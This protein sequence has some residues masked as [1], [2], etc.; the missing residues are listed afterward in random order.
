MAPAHWR[1]AVA[2]A[3]RLTQPAPQVVR[4]PIARPGLHHGTAA[5]LPGGASPAV[6]QLHPGRC[7]LYAQYK[8]SAW[9]LGGPLQH[10]V[11][12]DLAPAYTGAPGVAR[13]LCYFSIS[14]IHIADKESPAQPIYIGLERAVW[15]RSSGNRRPIRQSC[16]RRQQVLDAAVQTI[17]ALHRSNAL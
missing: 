17:N 2:A 12:K 3:T 11:R 9:T 14:D 13:L 16:S 1:S 5:G 4:W 7:A 10:V 15:S 8:Y 6:R